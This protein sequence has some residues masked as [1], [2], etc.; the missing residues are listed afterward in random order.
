[1]N[2]PMVQINDTEDQDIERGEPDIIEVE[3]C[4]ECGTNRWLHW[5]EAN[6][7]DDYNEVWECMK[8]GERVD[9]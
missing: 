3:P 4:P 2:M 5:Y 1:M 8:C 9:S 6:G 7:P